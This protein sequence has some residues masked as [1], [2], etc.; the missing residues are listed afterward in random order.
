MVEHTSWWWW[1][2]VING[3]INDASF[4]VALGIASS[5]QVYLMVKVGTAREG[6][7][8]SSVTQR[9]DGQGSF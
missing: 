7:P 3:M 1:L 8:S 9:G 4:G 5:P 6:K 2:K